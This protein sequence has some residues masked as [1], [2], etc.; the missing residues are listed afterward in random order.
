MTNT[1]INAFHSYRGNNIKYLGIFKYGLQLAS[2]KSI[3]VGKIYIYLQKCLELRGSPD[4]ENSF[5]LANFIFL[6]IMQE[7]G[8]ISPT[9]IKSIKIT[10]VTTGNKTV[11]YKFVADW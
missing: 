5:F 11:K 4:P 3:F 2:Y 9:A 7:M 6:L 1:S 10:V 8:S